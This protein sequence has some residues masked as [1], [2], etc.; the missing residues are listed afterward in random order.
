[1]IGRAWTRPEID[2]LVETFEGDA[3]TLALSR[4]LGRTHEAVLAKARRLQLTC[5]SGGTLLRKAPP[6]MIG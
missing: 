3:D 4:E 5:R 2:R 1:M 6:A